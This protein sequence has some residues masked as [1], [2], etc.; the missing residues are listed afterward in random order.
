MAAVLGSKP[1]LSLFSRVHIY[2]WSKHWQDFSTV[3]QVGNIPGARV[4]KKNLK[5]CTPTCGF[6]CTDADSFSACQ[7][8]TF[9]TS[10]PTS[11]LRET[12][13]WTGWRC[14]LKWDVHLCVCLCVVVLEWAWLIVIPTTGRWAPTVDDRNIFHI[15]KIQWP[16]ISNLQKIYGM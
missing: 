11:R 2:K 9:L 7:T 5:S 8:Q 13:Q 16:K 15:F 3:W 14:E 1:C 12:A 4:P 10:S 6:D